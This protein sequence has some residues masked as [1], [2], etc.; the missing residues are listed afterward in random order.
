MGIFDLDTG[1]VE[2]LGYHDHLVNRIVVNDE[3]TKAAS[4]SSDYSIH[5]WDLTSR[6]R[7][8]TLLGHNDDVEDFV[9]A[10]AETGVSASRDRRLIIWNLRTGAV[11]CV[12]DGHEKDVLAVVAAGGKVYSSGDDKTL[13]VWDLASGK[14]LSMW[15][16]FE[17]ETDTCAIDLRRQ[18]AVLGC[19]DGCVRVFDAVTGELKHLIEAHKSGIKKVAVSPT[20][21]DILSAAYDQKIIAW[22][23]QTFAKKV[24]LESR[25]GTWERSLTWS[26]DGRQILGGT[27]DGTV[28]LWDAATG[29]FEREIGRDDN[30][31][32]NP[33]FNDVAVADNGEIATVSDDGFLR[34][35]RLTADEVALAG[36]GRAARWPRADE[37]GHV[38]SEVSPG[39][40]RFARSYAAHLSAH[41]R[42]AGRRGRR[43]LGRRAGQLGC[44]SPTIRGTS[45][46]IFTACYSSRIVRVSPT[47]EVRGKIEVHEG[48]VKALRLHPR[49]T[50]GVSCGADGLLLSWTFDGELVER[51]LGH[52]A[53]INDVDLD[54]TGKRLA[55][56]SRDFTL[57]V[58][59]VAS[60][61]LEH[62]ISI[63]RKSLKSVCFWNDT[64][65]VIGDYWGGLIRV[66]LE[67]ETFRRSVEAANGI[68]A[69]ARSGEHLVA[70]SYDGDNLLAAS[71]FDRGRTLLRHAA[72]AQ[73]GAMNRFV[74]LA[75]PRSGSNMLC[76]MLGSHPRI[77]CHHEL[78][79]PKGVRLALPL[80]GSAFTLGSIDERER[81][82]IAFLERAWQANMGFSCVGFKLTHRQNE[83]VFRRMLEDR[84]VAK[85]VLGRRNRLKTYVSYRMSEALGEWEVYRGEELIRQR[86]RVRVE[87][88]QFFERVAFD[89]AYYNEIRH[90]LRF[91]GAGVDRRRVRRPVR[92]R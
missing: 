10:D 70:A 79:N 84:S 30:E 7:E 48:A 5:I 92:G 86:P 56:V 91:A 81:D 27:F 53:I 55:S 89:E 66:D 90:A 47:G 40:G 88:R 41:G 50:L 24:T 26:P 3:G 80:R 39:G 60:G 9:F 16:P 44:A 33:C 22:D 69:V 49:E 13:R 37:R 2:L 87:P 83:A 4:C 6:R 36:Q 17:N 38:E 46:Q 29:A 59:D 18:R 73:P 43:P 11:R 72:K 63:G 34:I 28:V 85:V 52:T 68:S 21:G 76:T 57:K 42:R 77:L 74:I 23:S 62:S 15:G 45:A 35:G 75:A 58:F 14:Q 31:P 71:R 20:T 54:P 65:V 67:T 78:F 19:D 25:P 61:R 1:H 64:T 32:G 82:P 12:L 8:M 51:Y